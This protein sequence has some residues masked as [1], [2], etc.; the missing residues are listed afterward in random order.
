MGLS[1]EYRVSGPTQHAAQNK[2]AQK[3]KTVQMKITT[4]TFLLRFFIQ[5]FHY[6]FPKALA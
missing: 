6:I 2:Y 1:N 4:E 3:R 5:R